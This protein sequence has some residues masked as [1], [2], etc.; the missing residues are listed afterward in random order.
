MTTIHAKQIMRQRGWS[1]RAAAPRLGV[2]YQHLALVLTGRRESRRLLHA[3]SKLPA[4]KEG[5]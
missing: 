2:C 1:Y 3:I 4:R 5:A